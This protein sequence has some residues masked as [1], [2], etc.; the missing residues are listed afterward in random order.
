MKRNYVGFA[1]KGQVYGP[2][3]GEG[4]FAAT[5][6][7]GHYKVEYNE[8]QD[9]LMVTNFHPKLDEILNLG[10]KEYNATLKNV[11]KFLEPATAEAFKKHGFLLKRS[12]LFHGPAGTGKSVLATRLAD[13]AVEAKNAIVLYPSGY[14]ALERMLEVISETD[15]ERFVV[16]ALEEFDDKVNARD[17]S[18]WTTLLDGQFQSGNRILVAT[19]NYI[20]SIP[21]RLLRPGR[22]SSLILIP[23]LTPAARKTYLQSKGLDEKLVEQI[24]EVTNEFTVDE[25]KEVVQNCHILG[26]PVKAVVAAITAAR[27]M[28]NSGEE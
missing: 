24:V 10:G 8:Y 27:K 16:L 5:L 15:K 14:E 26:E 11:A 25:L 13:M 1:K 21:Q 19:T 12:F 22:F 3:T 23:A 17:E 6:P 28:G 18:E 4:D 2:A 20:E 9:E 7:A